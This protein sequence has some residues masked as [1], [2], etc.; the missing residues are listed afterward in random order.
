MIRV[1]RLLILATLFY[2]IAEGVIAIWAGVQAG[3]VALVAFGADSYLEVAAASV[4]FWRLG[5]HDPERGERIEQRAIRFIGWTFLVLA[6]AVVFQSLWAFAGGRGAGESI[7]G[8]AL[9]AASV[10]VMPAVA[11]WKL[12]I[13]AKGNIFALAAEAKETVACSY[14]S[15]TLLLGMA[16]NALFGWWWLDAVTALLLTPWLIREGM[17]NVRGEQCAEDAQLCSCR[18]CL[19]GLRAC[20]LPCC[21]TSQPLAAR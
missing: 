12:R 2:N 20:K 1:A 13:A 8:I 6:G 3:S 14:L 9:A 11:L 10:T 16:A 17:E 7:V 21:T 4:V 5:V 15:I 18:G 19:Y